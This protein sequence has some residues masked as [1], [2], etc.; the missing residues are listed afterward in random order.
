MFQT[1]GYT[2]LGLLALSTVYHNAR[3]GIEL[4]NNP[5]PGKL[6]TVGDGRMHIYGKGKGSPTILFTCGNGMAF[7][8]GNFYPA[9]IRLAEETRVLVYDRFGYGW[10]ESTSRPRTIKQINADLRELLDKAGESGPFILVGHSLGGAEAVQFAQ[11]YPELVA[12]VVTLDGTTPAFYKDRKPLLVENT[13]AST[14]ARFMSVTG[15]LRALTRLKLL[16][17]AGASLPKE[18]ADLTDMMTYDKVYS[19]EAVEEVKALVNHDEEQ[20]TLSSIPL[21]ILTAENLEMQKK[22]PEVYQ[23]FAN[24]QTELL[25][26]S[27]ESRQKIIQDADHYFP[28]KKPDVVTEEVLSFF[29]ELRDRG[30]PE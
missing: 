5:P 8:L 7:T 13:V 11:R 28:I 21:L 24:S 27:S 16:S 25:S 1:V 10:S 26:L 15:A 19:R 12:G 3:K 9:F 2:L 30:K 23:Y 17:T 22:Q 18:I 20:G 4:R 6:I 29:D 14:V